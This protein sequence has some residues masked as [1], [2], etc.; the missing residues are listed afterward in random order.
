MPGETFVVFLQAVCVANVYDQGYI[1]TRI[2]SI[3]ANKLKNW[4][5]TVDVAEIAQ[6]MPHITLR[7]TSALVKNG[8]LPF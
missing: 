7:H 6:V 1:H 3:E 4:F 5:T 2:F 8:L